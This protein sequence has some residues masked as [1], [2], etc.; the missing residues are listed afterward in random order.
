M[1]RQDIAPIKSIV[2]SILNHLKK[3]S[4]IKEE[5]VAV[6]WNKVVD[7]KIKN[8]TRPIRLKDNTLIV[9]TKNSNWLFELET[10]YKEKILN[11]LRNEIKEIE[12][13]DIRFRIGD[14]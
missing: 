11:R 12:I 6:I 1:K 5:E 3:Q 9:N 4:L 2:D 10:R 7:K 13:K 8:H 14:V